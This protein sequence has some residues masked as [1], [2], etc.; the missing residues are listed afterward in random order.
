M[1]S[2]GK[3]LLE[4]TPGNASVALSIQE[5]NEGKPSIIVGSEIN[6]RS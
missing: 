2:Y 4:F 1:L 3:L 5:G 6:K